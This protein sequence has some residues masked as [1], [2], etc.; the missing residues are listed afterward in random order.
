MIF[1]SDSMSDLPITFH[2]SSHSN[3]RW[4]LATGF[5]D[6]L[7][8]SARVGRFT[9]FIGSHEIRI[10]VPSFEERTYFL[11]ESLNGKTE[12]IQNLTRVKDECDKLARQAAQRVAFAGAGVMGSWWIT[13]GVLTFRLYLI[14]FEPSQSLIPYIRY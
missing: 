6:F 14:S 8:E 4:S 5:G 1:G 7:R 9:I 11:R 10:I 2:I 12:R 3:K 13:V